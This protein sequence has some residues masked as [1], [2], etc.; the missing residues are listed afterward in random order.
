[1]S[2]W[3]SVKEELP[4]G[5]GAK[6]KVKMQNGHELKCYYHRDKMLWLSY[7]INHKASHFQ[8]CETDEFLYGVTHW[9]SLPKPPKD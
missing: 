9:M 7:Y 5:P 8:D 4:D 1:M 3:I 2:E 6:V